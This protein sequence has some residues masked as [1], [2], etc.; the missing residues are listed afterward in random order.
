MFEAV[1]MPDE[2]PASS[3]KKP[4]ARS[5]VTN[6]K[7]LLA[8]IDGRSTEARRFRD[9]CS[10]FADDLGGVAGLT[11]AQRALVK[12][13]AALVVQSETM[14][15]AA[16]RGEPVSDEQMTRIANTL[17]RTV[18]RLEKLGLK[19]RVTARLSVP[20]YLA[21]RDARNAAADAEAVD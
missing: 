5:R 11:E 17:G 18:D 9:L 2:S 8:N 14:A 20:E 1:R 3:A 12:Q 15:G 10:S 7:E 4:E 19:R 16:I 6:G 13:A 21:A